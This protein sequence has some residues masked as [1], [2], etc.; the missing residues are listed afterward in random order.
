MNLTKF[1][2]VGKAVLVSRI[3]RKRIPL[4]VMWRIT[5][6]CNSR[7][8]YCSIWKKEQKE[9]TTGQIKSLIDQMAA[10]GTQ[11][12]GFV[13]GEAFL[14]EDFGEIVDYVKEKKIFVTLVSNG[15]MVP[16]NMDIVRKLDYLVIS[17]DGRK[18]NHERGRMEGSFDNVIKSFDACHKNN[19]KVLTNTVLNKY[20]LDDIDYIL[21]TV[22]K[23][24]FKSTFNVLQ[25]KT[26][27]FP[28]D[29]LYRKTF[30]HLIR[31]KDEGAP[32]VLSKKAM[33][34]LQEWPD[35]RRYVTKDKMGDFKCWAGRLIF[36]IDTDGRIAPCDI[37]T[38]IRDSNPSCVELGLSKAISSISPHGCQAC[39]CSHVIEYNYMFS[40]NPSVIFDWGKL[41]SKKG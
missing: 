15:C 34:F 8:S 10:S 17:F 3:T 28:P 31:K 5:N 41:V 16:D 38:H 29:E 1:A 11:R 32:I 14:R 13:G 27:C 23:Y 6:K 24:S 9:L 12:I 33:R 40:L 26:D 35:Y 39:T 36:N 19:V 2:K 22:Q 30:E 21:D 37:L 7:C 4:N 25:G 20:N 18:E